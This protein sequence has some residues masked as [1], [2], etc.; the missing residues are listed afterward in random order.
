MTFI[1]SEEEKFV[2]LVTEGYTKFL[3]MEDQKDKVGI[4][5]K[6]VEIMGEETKRKVL[7]VL[8]E[9]K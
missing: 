9:F 3:H 2:M 7:S 6:L 4:M 1:F 8:K 5:K